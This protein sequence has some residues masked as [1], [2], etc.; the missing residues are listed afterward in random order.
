MD[1]IQTIED[2]LQWLDSLSF[3]IGGYT[4]TAL[5]I[6]VYTWAAGLIV[7]LISCIIMPGDVDGGD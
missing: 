4:F 5:E 6:F 1:V 7:G 3:T 2:C